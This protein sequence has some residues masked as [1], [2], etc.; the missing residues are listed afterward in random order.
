MT[1]S[2][3]KI[4]LVLI[5]LS[6]MIMVLVTI[7]HFFAGGFH[8][9]TNEIEEYRREINERDDV[10]SDQSEFRHLVAAKKESICHKIS[11]RRDN[12]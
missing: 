1:I 7:N 4:V 11:R 5:I 12:N 10:I 9:T 8:S 6:V 2:I 3:L